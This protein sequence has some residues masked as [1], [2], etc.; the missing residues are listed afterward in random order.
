MPKNKRTV[1]EK[2]I[3]PAAQEMLVRADE[4]GIGTAFSRADDMVPCNIGSAGMCCKLCGMGPCRLTKDGQT[5]VCG[6][7]IDTIQA[8][9]LI[10]AIS[11]GA[12]AHSDHGRDMAF[13]L[14]AVANGEAEGYYLR[15]V[16]KLRTVA[17]RYD[18]PIDE[19]DPSLGPEDAPV[20]IVDFSDY[21]CPYCAQYHL[22]VFHEL[23]EKYSGKI[24]FV[25]KDFPLVGIH[26][27]AFSASEAALCANEQ[28]AFWEYQT[29]LY[30]NDAGFGAEAY[31]L[32][33]QKLGL[34]IDSF[35]ECITEN[36]Y[37]DAVQA[38]YDFAVNLGVQ[39]TPTFFINGIGVVG[40]LPIDIFSEVI[41]G[42]LEGSN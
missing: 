19:N 40:A 26:G 33:A 11:A 8:R 10:R 24:R 1:E 23:K 37:T 4:L 29:L 41:D 16:A 6:A 12:A 13:T 15:D 3:D 18:I 9:N 21:E 32:Y 22:T 5:G 14:K 25:H 7:T 42:E 20:T 36:R 17:A 28:D 35:N 38:D 2:T 34:D 30:E 27:N 39:S 31:I